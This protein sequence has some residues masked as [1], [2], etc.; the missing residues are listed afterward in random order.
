MA[1]V[2]SSAT[3]TRAGQCGELPRRSPGG[4][5]LDRRTGAAP[6]IPRAADGAR[7]SPMHPTLAKSGSAIDAST[8]RP[9]TTYAGRRYVPFL[10]FW[11][12]AVV[13]PLLRRK[14]LHMAGGGQPSGWGWFRNER[15]A[16]RQCADA[17]WPSSRSR[18]AVRAETVIRSDPL[19]RLPL[20][21]RREARQALSR[22]SAPYAS[23]C[24]FP[25]P[26]RAAPKLR[27]VLPW[28][29]RKGKGLRRILT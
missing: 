25:R 9:M 13:G 28:G 6:P 14:E 1:P 15:R 7:A 12:L 27:L 11:A 24:R 16:R 18:Q 19:W 5:A 29:F 17:A 2:H 20:P 21:C 22:Y 3:R 8:C 26:R 4:R 10:F 23:L